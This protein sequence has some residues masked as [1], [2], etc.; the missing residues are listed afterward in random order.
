MWQVK[1]WNFRLE[2]KIVGANLVDEP[3][4]VESVGQIDFVKSGSK[5]PEFLIRPLFFI[6]CKNKRANINLPIT[7]AC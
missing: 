7:E 5:Y 2:V 4:S 1:N 3:C 6:M